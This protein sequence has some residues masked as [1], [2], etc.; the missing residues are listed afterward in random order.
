MS[1]PLLAQFPHFLLQM[2]H[3]PNFYTVVR[4]R[5]DRIAIMVSLYFE[6]QWILLQ[7]LCD[8]Y[9]MNEEKKYFQHTAKFEGGVKF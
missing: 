6:K 5:N 9:K 4:K 1:L 7:D 3:S 2:I 8:Y